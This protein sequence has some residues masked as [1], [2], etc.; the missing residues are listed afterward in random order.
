[1]AAVRKSAVS[2]NG[3]GLQSGSTSRRR[4]R[5]TKNPESS[6]QK[7][8]NLAT[9]TSSV[10]NKKRPAPQSLSLPLTPER[11]PL[12]GSDSHQAKR[13]RYS[14]GLNLSL[15]FAMGRVINS[16][17]SLQSQ[18]TEQHKNLN[19]QLPYMPIVPNAKAMPL[20]LLRMHTFHRHST[21]LAFL[22]VAAA[23]VVY[24]WT[25][26][27][28]ELWG[29]NY[30]RLQNLQ[31]YERQMTTTNATL[32]NKIAE[33][34]ENSKMG[35]VSPDPSDTVFIPPASHEPEVVAPSP[36]PAAETKS[37]SSSRLGY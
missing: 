8:A 5:R 23:L 32:T 31:R 20:W 17:A 28:Q 37:P 14:R 21:G 34:A 36:K 2:S 9:E 3:S 22:L 26:Y 10:L 33:E 18:S 13:R 30:R 25:V 1:M 35:L 29:Q 16:S 15:P 11:K 24:G 7:S 4:K 12:S 6:V 19:T 27:T